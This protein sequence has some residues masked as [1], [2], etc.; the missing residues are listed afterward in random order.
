MIRAA[1]GR[2]RASGW[3]VVLLATGLALAGCQ[4]DAPEA[5]GGAQSSET[6]SGAVEGTVAGET[7]EGSTAERTEAE[8]S[9]TGAASN[10]ATDEAVEAAQSGESPAEAAEGE[11]RSAAEEEGTTGAA[12]GGDSTLDEILTPEAWDSERV[13]AAIRSSDLAQ[14]RQDE[15]VE[16]VRSVEDSDDPDLRAAAI[17]EIRAVLL[18]E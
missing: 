17:E 1:S 18:P 8:T 6:G 9:D 7:G 10:A 11:A 14:P 15:L 12:A 16:Q 4:E 3:S 5:D 13:I 2:M